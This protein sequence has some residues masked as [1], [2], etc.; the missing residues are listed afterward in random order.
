MAKR[1]PPNA[2]LATRQ[3]R[4]LGPA[5]LPYRGH[6]ILWPAIFALNLVSYFLWHL[7]RLILWMAHSAWSH[8]WAILLACWNGLRV[9]TRVFWRIVTLVGVVYLVYD[10]FFEADATLSA[11]ASDPS[12]AFEFPFT[13]TNNSHI[14]AIRNVAWNC[15]I[16]R[17]RFG[18][19]NTLQEGQFI[20]GTAAMIAPGQSLNID[21][22]VIGPKSRMIRTPEKP[23]ISEA[24]LEIA[25]AYNADFFGIFSLHRRPPPA[26]FT[27]F[28]DASNPQWIKGN[29]AK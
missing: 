17:L 27:W 6:K 12:F 23:S 16:L 4:S 5:T 19:N 9:S 22:S 15:H 10:R 11:P 1:P 7:G 3:E 24:T 25:L 29:F 18:N 8:R 28:P 26:L 21:C 13:I 14:F 2:A 20:Q